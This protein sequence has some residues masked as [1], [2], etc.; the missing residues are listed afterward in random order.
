MVV[1]Q[2][3]LFGDGV[4]ARV[5]EQ[6]LKEFNMHTVVRLPNGVFS[7]YTPIPT[8]VLF[9]DRRGPTDSI[10][11]YEIPL[12]EGRK[13]YTKTMPLR[14]EEFEP[15]LEWWKKR[16]ENKQAW[17]VRVEQLLKYG[18]DGAL[19]SVDLDLKNPNA[20]DDLEH[21]PPD[22]LVEGIINAETRILEIMHDIKHA[23]QVDHTP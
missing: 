18:A 10:W 9:F 5:K 2:G 23:L 1:P 21:L 4:C 6:L 8:N 12:P 15:C 13:N 11:Y 22:H 7:P 14:A 3:V 20:P 16:E 19:E 17:Q